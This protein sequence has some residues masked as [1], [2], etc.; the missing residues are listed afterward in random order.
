[1][2]FIWDG[3]GSISV[4]TFVACRSRKVPMY[5]MIEVNVSFGD[6]NTELGHKSISGTNLASEEKCKC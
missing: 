4:N 1:M 5:L 6:K 2:D 3:L